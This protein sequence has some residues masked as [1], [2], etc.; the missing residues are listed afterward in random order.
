MHT[1]VH[2]PTLQIPAPQQIGGEPL[3]LSGLAAGPLSLVRLEVRLTL[4]E[5][6]S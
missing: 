4:E 2:Q 5:P 1:T 3:V 6:Y